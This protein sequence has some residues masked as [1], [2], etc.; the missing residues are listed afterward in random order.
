MSSHM[1]PQTISIKRKRTEAPVDSLRINHEVKRQKSQNLE[2]GFTSEPE[3]Q[4]FFR[5]LTK[6]GDDA[7]LASAPPTPTAQR[8]FRLDPI[9][10]IGAKRHFVEEQGP[11]RD[12][13]ALVGGRVQSGQQRR[14]ERRAGPS[15]AVVS[16]ASTC[17]LAPFTSPLTNAPSL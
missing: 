3:V 12:D 14:A 13:S 16:Q 11:A 17:T 7:H 4:F 2:S 9:S 15:M 5:R 10:R 6:P 8:R 1:P